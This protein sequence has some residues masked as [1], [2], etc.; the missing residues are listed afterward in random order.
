M[1]GRILILTPMCIKV[2][3]KIKEIHPI[4]TNFGRS[5][6]KKLIFLITLYEKTRYNNNIVMTIIAPNSSD[7]TET[8]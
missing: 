2:C 7:I 8:M 3:N 5:S 1:V 4:K 6:F